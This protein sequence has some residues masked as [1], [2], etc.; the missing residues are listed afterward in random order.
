MRT[1]IILASSFSKFLHQPSPLKSIPAITTILPP[2]V[3]VSDSHILLPPLRALWQP[4]CL[5]N[6]LQGG[7]QLKES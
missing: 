4:L 3:H 2:S 7:A 6:Q 1:L 5:V